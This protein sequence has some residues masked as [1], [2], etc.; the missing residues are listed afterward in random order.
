M[1]GNVSE[2]CLN[3]TSEGFI[4][5]GGSWNSLPQAWGF[6]AIYPGFKHSDEVGFRCVLNFKEATGNQGTMRIDLDDEVPRFNPAPE[7]EVRKLIAHYDYDGQAPLNEHVTD[8]TEADAWWRERIEYDG[9]HGERALAYLYLPKHLSGP[10]Q[11]IHFV[12]AGD[13]THRARAVP[14]CIEAD[15]NAFVRSGRAVFVVVLRG[16]LERDR[17]LGWEE[18]DPTT[19]AYVDE[20]ARDVIDLRRG[21][22]YL[23]T[24]NELD[25]RRVAYMTASR[26][27]IV[28]ALPAIEPR[29][30]TSIFVGDGVGISV[31][32]WNRAVNPVHF[33]P[34]I[35]VPSL[36]VHGR[37]DE[38]APLKSAAE[39]LYNLLT[40]SKEMF[41]YDGGHRPDPEDLVPAVNSWLDKTLGPVTRK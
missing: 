6:Y 17:P 9:A 28:M 20:K 5:S 22:D 18:P 26:G 12:P 39:P 10:H 29:Y 41:L 38:G 16:Y 3:E 15:Y 1:A 4:A 24:R 7:A 27:D 40:K 36:L 32:Q 2:W 33:L 30:S 11:V 19:I 35:Q 13:V 37:Y 34:L 25:A 8:R 21:L 23:L 31:K 14:K